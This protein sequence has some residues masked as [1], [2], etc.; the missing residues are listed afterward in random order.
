MSSSQSDRAGIAYRHFNTKLPF[1]WTWRSGANFFRIV[2]VAVAIY[3]DLYCRNERLPNA[4]WLREHVHPSLGEPLPLFAFSGIGYVFAY[5]GIGLTYEWLHRRR[6]NYSAEVLRARNGQIKEELKVWADGFATQLA[7]GT[8]WHSLV[9]PYSPWWGYF[10]THDYTPLWFALH[11]LVYFTY[12]DYASFA[13]HYHILHGSAWAWENLHLQ[14]HQIRNPTA[15]GG[16]AV[17]PIEGIIQLA[18][19]S[20]LMFWFM[21]IDYWAHQ[22]LM[23]LI[24]LGPALGGHDGSEGHGG[25]G[26][27]DL[28]R[29]YYHHITWHRGRLGY[30]NYALFWPLWD[31]VY[32]TYVGSEDDYKRELAAAKARPE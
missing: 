12:L 25:H 17:H 30:K 21:P 7:V 24:L 32:G 14:H 5:L 10:D 20:N 19:P 27:F 16:A 18:L 26:P 28:S 13:V 2:L 3:C 29:H 4:G 15:F 31:R 1:T 6:I 11:V 23:L 8:T 9:N 22:A